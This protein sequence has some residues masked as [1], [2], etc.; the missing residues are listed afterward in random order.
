MGRFARNV[1][2]GF[3]FLLK[4]PAAQVGFLFL[5]VSSLVLGRAGLRLLAVLLCLALV[6]AAVGAYMNVDLETDVRGST[7]GD[8]GPEE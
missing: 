8:R 3:S 2:A 1:R 5:V 4:H 7:T 6:F